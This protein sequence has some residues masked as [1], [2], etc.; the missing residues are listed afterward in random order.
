MHVSNLGKN[1]GYGAGSPPP[2]FVHLQYM[3]NTVYVSSYVTSQF[4]VVQTWKN[5]CAL[6]LQNVLRQCGVCVIAQNVNK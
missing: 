6:K 2:L 1:L 3:P 4:T 5:G